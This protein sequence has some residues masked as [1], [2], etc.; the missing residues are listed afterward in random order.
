M[1]ENKTFMD[2]I[3]SEE[4]GYYSDFTPLPDDNASIQNENKYRINKDN[5]SNNYK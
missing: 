3:Y 1:S 5:Y 2:N 4:N